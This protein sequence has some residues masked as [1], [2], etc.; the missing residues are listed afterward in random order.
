MYRFTTS[1]SI[2]PAVSAK[3]R[4]P[5]S[6]LLTSSV[7]NQSSL[8][9]RKDLV[10]LSAPNCYRNHHQRVERKLCFGQDSHQQYSSQ[11]TVF[12]AF[13]ARLQYRQL[14]QKTLLATEIPECHLRDHS[15]GIPGIACKVSQKG[16]SKYPQITHG[17]YLQTNTGS[18]YPEYS[19]DGP[20]II[21]N[22]LLKNPEMRN[23]NPQC[24][25]GFP[26]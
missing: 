12:S 7:C 8:T 9:T 2:L 10:F 24:L 18:H 17:V 5:Q 16:P 14:V 25:S 19:K 22:T 4:S 6:C 26:V 3:Y 23:L 1:S 21:L 20:V 13:T 11:P 15:N